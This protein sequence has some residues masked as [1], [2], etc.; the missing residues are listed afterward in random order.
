MGII[1]PEDRSLKQPVMGFCRNPECCDVAGVEFNFMIE[2]DHAACPKC[3]A[4]RE[5]MIG[6]LVLTHLLLPL[7]GGPIIGRGGIQFVI[8]CDSQRAYTATATNLEA[9]TDNPKISNCPG[10]LSAI[11]KLNVKKPTGSSLV[12]T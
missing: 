10:C 5:P 4:D 11:E 8:A 1:V 9:V 12:V 7:K 3:G 6:M 2:H